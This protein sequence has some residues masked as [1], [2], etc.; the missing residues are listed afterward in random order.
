M[1]ELKVLTAGNVCSESFDIYAGGEKV[2]S[3]YIDPDYYGT[4]QRVWA[5]YVSAN[6]NFNFSDRLPTSQTAEERALEMLADS[7]DTNFQRLQKLGEMSWEVKVALGR[8]PDEECA[9]A[10]HVLHGQEV[11]LYDK[12][13]DLKSHLAP[14]VEGEL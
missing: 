1:T 10:V 4:F 6:W 13:K 9:Y 2:A 11:R 7:V 12:I 3:A 5:V 8:L 14:F